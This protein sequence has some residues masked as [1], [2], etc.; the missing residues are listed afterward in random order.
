MSL[1]ADLQLYYSK[2]KILKA[3]STA[4]GL[5]SWDRETVMPKKASPDRG[6]T[7]AILSGFI[8]QL[9]IEK[10]FV[11]LVERLF[12]QSDKLNAFDRRSVLL[13][14][15]DLD[16]SIKLPQKFVEETQEL[17]NHAH[18]AWVAAKQSNN[19]SLFAP[20][21]TQ[22]VANR[23]KYASY[24]NP[25][26]NAYDVQIDDYEEGVNQAFLDPLFAN[27]KDGIERMMPAIL[28]KQKQVLAQN[29][30]TQ[31]PQNPLDQ[32]KVDRHQLE[33]AIRQII[34]TVGFDWE[35]GMLGEVEHPFET[36]LSA[37]DVRL[38]T[39]FEPL[40][41]SFTIMSTIHELGHGLY[42]QNVDHQYQKSIFLAHGTSLGIHES[43]SRLLENFIARPSEFWQYFLPKFQQLMPEL[44]NVSF[45]Q[46]IHS[47]NYVAPSLIRTEADEVTYN[48]HIILRYEIERGLLND[49]IKVADLPEIWSTKMQ[50]LIG[51]K[52]PNDTQGVLQDVHWSW[53]DLGY[54][55]TYTLGNLNA[56]QLWAKFIAAHP[57]WAEEVAQGN[58]HSYFSWFKKHVWQ[59]G[60]FYE[61]EEIMTMATGEK[62]NAKYLL[63]F[64]EKK[65][66]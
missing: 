25:D 21:L 16:K 17:T 55:P 18:A 58:F 66:A 10:D 65:F 27:L 20:W 31:A 29:G 24:I 62:T 45:D 61:P 41:N 12:N 22:V 49:S 32:I 7:M 28:A 14:K 59:H 57:K 19:F 53:G 4:Q 48:L 13:T 47:L 63:Q 60:A 39:H 2:L 30:K 51:I 43:Q 42:E 11:N 15:R 44:K 1:K 9:C 36:T 5:L 3:F 37:N 54:F 38:N 33:V 64:L 50:E 35:R 40:D 56:A 52:P 23:Q 6:E 26:L 8:H 34:S 46:L